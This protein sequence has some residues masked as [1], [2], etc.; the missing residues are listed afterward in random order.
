M[1]VFVYICKY[2]IQLYVF[3]QDGNKCSLIT[4]AFIRVSRVCVYSS[5]F[6]C[7]HARCM[8]V[9]MGLLARNQ[10]EMMWKMS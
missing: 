2:W 8:Y 5:L 9:D 7:L 4:N 3:Y 6:V 10:H 1:Y